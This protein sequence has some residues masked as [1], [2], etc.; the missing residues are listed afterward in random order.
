MSEVEAAVGKLAGPPKQEDGCRYTLVIP[1]DIAAS[2]QEAID[3]MEQLRARFKDSSLGNFKGPMAN[4]QR[5]PATYA[6][7]LSVDVSGR[8]V[9]GELGAAAAGAQLQSWL[10]PQQRG[11]EDTTE[12][13][14]SAQKLGRYAARPVW[15]QRANRPRADLRARAGPG[16]A[17][18]RRHSARGPR[19]RPSPDLPF[20]ADNPY[21]VPNSTPGDK[22]PC[23]LL[24]R[25]EAE[26]V[27]GPLAV[28]PYRAS[29]DSPPLVLGEGDGCAFYAAGHHVFSIVPRWRDGQQEFN[30]NK[31][32]G[33][34]MSTVLPQE[35]VVLKGPWDEAHIA[36]RLGRCCS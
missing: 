22:D 27:L 4:Y 32:M 17:A 23:S 14:S 6:V 31:G 10:P 28:E 5:E 2:R 21:Q 33:A 13:S 25:S 12:Q 19:P 3:E 34:L 30:M 20:P 26:A 1:D 16:R 35:L 29:S 9:A 7:T 18:L 24:T 15:V 36:A 8:S 11:G